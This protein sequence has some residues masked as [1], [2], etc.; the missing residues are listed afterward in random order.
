MIVNPPRTTTPQTCSTR[1]IYV[2]ARI[3]INT[4]FLAISRI[5]LA[6]TGQF[7]PG[8][9]HAMRPLPT[10]Q[11]RAP[12]AHAVFARVHGS[13][14]RQVGLGNAVDP[15]HAAGASDECC[16]IIDTKIASILTSSPCQD[17]NQ[18]PA[19]GSRTAEWLWLTRARKQ[20]HF[21]FHC[22]NGRPSQGGKC[23]S[24]RLSVTYTWISCVFRRQSPTHD[25][26]VS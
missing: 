19:I 1:S 21:Y 14:F 5:F 9:L 8:Q 6:R 3:Y 22:R 23:I 7:Q 25:I 16:V 12:A 2:N 20:G 24:C 10:R 15:A 11:T 18:V 13:I 17:A 26:P 4:F